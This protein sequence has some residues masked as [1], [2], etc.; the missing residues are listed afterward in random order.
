MRSLLQTLTLSSVYKR[1]AGIFR[2]YL[3]DEAALRVL[4]LGCGKR[5][6][7]AGFSGYIG[8]DR[9]RYPPKTEGKFISADVCD[10]P[11][12]DQSFDAIVSTSL[13]HHLDLEQADQVVRE[14]SRVLKSD[15]RIIIADGVFPESGLNVFGHLLRHLDRGRYVRGREDFRRLFRQWFQLE[16]DIFFTQGIYAYSVLV[17][18]KL[19]DNES[20]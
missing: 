15:G 4:D 16:T 3:T 2:Q 6:N 17:M 5:G 10:I 18:G 9:L 14:M 19:R 13:F 7:F 12:P 1:L 11:C 20:I 8:L